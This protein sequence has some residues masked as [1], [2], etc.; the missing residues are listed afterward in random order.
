MEKVVVLLSTYNG[1]KYLKEQIDSLTSQQDVDVEILVRDDGSTDR[2]KDM[3]DVWSKEG[4]L[5]WYTGENLKPARSFLDLLEK[6]PEA[7]YYAFCD[8]D[9]YWLPDK[10]S[11]A[12]SMLQ[13]NQSR[14]ALYFCQ[15]QLVDSNL[16]K[17]KS[18]IIN[19]LLTFGESLVYHF[20]GG[21]TMVFNK[22]LRNLVLQ[23]KPSFLSMHDVWVYK[24]ALALGANIYFDSTPH[25]LY[26]QHGGNVIGQGKESLIKLIKKR[27]INVIVKRSQNRYKTALEIKRG[28]FDMMAPEQKEILMKFIEGK[29]IF[30]KRISLFFDSRYKCSLKRVYRNF[31]IAVLFNTY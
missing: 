17:I 4:I 20:I 23:Y 25:I 6:A 5:T 9:D 29:K 31:R 18:V 21:C 27:F 22:S 16:N 26:R 13:E 12:V 2:T 15:T 14:A 19:P 8:Q 11:T 24:V 3:L 1:E 10:L 28:Y 30:L 7:D